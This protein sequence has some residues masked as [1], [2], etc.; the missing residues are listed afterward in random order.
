MAAAGEGRQSEQETDSQNGYRRFVDFAAV[1]VSL[2]V[3]GVGGWLVYLPIK[4]HGGH[5]R[6]DRDTPHVLTS[7]VIERAGSPWDRPKTKR[8]IVRSATGTTTTSVV[9]RAGRQTKVTT[10]VGDEKRSLLEQL[11]AGS[12]YFIVRLA[13]VLVAAFLAG[14]LVQRAMLGKF[15]IKFPFVELSDIPKAAADSKQALAAL[16]SGIQKQLDD[17]ATKTDD[18]FA[19]NTD[20]IQRALLA[21]AETSNAVQEL[22]D[23]VHQR[24]R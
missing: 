15:A 10:T 9:E 17:L 24:K 16:Q 8:T 20:A 12:G 6:E 21:L 22:R 7:R 19:N 3:L 11:F 2:V 1:I 13:F 14:A 4:E 5:F 18:R 23:R